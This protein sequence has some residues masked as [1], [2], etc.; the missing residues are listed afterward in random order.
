[1]LLHLLRLS[2]I[3]SAHV[4]GGIGEAVAA[5]EE[6]DRRRLLIIN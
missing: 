5:V 2:F 4:L 3:G 6:D 1:M